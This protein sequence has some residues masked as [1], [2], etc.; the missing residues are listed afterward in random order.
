[1]NTTCGN[2]D[3]AAAGCPALRPGCVAE[4]GFQDKVSG[5]VSTQEEGNAE[6]LAPPTSAA[7]ALVTRANRPGIARWGGL[8]HAP[9]LAQSSPRAPRLHPSKH[10]EPHT[11]VTK[12][13]TTARGAEGGTARGSFFSE[14]SHPGSSLSERDLQAALLRRA[15]IGSP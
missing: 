2:N 12:E 14:R 10:N 3:R 5:P 11:V 4:H 8:R 15:L 7:A 1:M 6:G 13:M 9:T